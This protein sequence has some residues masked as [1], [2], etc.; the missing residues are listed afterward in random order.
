MTA[1]RKIETTTQTPSTDMFAGEGTALFPSGS[2]PSL[3]GT[4][5]GLFPSGSAPSVQTSIS[6]GVETGLF[7]SGS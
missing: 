7:A 6:D 4:Q 5:T 2:A 3:D 1:I